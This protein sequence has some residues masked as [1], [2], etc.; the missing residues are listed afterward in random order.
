MSRKQRAAAALR[1]LQQCQPEY[2]AQLFD[3]WIEVATGGEVRR[4]WRAWMG[5]FP[6]W[7]RA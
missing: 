4:H 6:A 3:D 5:P 1:R 2:R 7:G